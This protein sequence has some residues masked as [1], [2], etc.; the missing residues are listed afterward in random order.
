MK[1][2]IYY[3]DGNFVKSQE[4]KISFYDG[5]FQRGN[6]IFESIRFKNNNLLHIDRHIQRLRNGLDYLEFKIQETD[7]NLIDLMIQVIT[8]NNLKTGIINL[9]ISSN[10][11]INNPLSST[12]NLY[13]SIREIKS[14]EHEMVK[15]IF[16]NEWDFPILRFKNSIKINS[17]AGN[18]KA[19]ITA[20]KQKAF[21]AVFYNRKH[22]VTE[23]T[24]RNI[25]FI[26]NGS[27][28]TPPLSLGILPG[29]TRDIILEL[30]KEHGY[31]YSEK[32]IKFE[33]INDMDEAFLTSSSYGVIPCYWKGWHNQNKETKKIKKI[34][35]SELLKGI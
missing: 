19:L 2:Y 3:I 6:A 20:K 1:Q 23:A 10:F 18:I 22:E 32:I 11:D 17:Y 4:A 15:I 30:C 9:M 8:K 16:L 34:L 27:V 28:I 12:I 13:I 21:D 33:D 26:K 5:G 7:E 25:F 14:I 35:D 29:T 24:M 31:D